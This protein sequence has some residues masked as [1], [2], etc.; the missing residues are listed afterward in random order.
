MPWDVV[1]I[2]FNSL[3]LNNNTFKEQSMSSINNISSLSNLSYLQPT[4]SA[5]QSVGG[6]DSDGDNDGSGSTGKVGKSNFLS[7]IEQAIEPKSVGQ[8]AHR[9]RALPPR[10]R[11]QTAVP[12]AQPR[13]SRPRCFPLCRTCLRRCIR[14]PGPRVQMAAIRTGTTTAARKYRESAAAAAAPI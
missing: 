6:G 5:T 8:L 10:L 4:A 1:P 14:L 12:P 11:P 9:L 2:P 3:I 13:V 7:I